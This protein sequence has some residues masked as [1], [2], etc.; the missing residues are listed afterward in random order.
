MFVA[1]GIW[2]LADV[3]SV[4][5][6]SEQTVPRARAKI[7]PPGRSISCK[8]GYGS[9]PVQPKNE[10]VSKASGFGMHRHVLWASCESPQVTRLKYVATL[11]QQNYQMSSVT[12][13]VF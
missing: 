5:P 10:K 1:C 9:N 11:C 3:S 4:S 8:R 7:V 6:S 12:S 13:F 2:C